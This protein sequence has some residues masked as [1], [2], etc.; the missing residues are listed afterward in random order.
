MT[1][2]LAPGLGASLDRAVEVLSTAPKVAL[3]CHVNP[4]P[5]A[6]GSMLALA[7]ALSAAGTEVACSW[8][9]VP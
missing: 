2:T 3:A 1:E 8:G 4:D 9:N 6:L 7:L 5:D